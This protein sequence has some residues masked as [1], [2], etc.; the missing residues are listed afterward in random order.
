VG[1]LLTVRAAIGSVFKF[2]HV[3]GILGSHGCECEDRCVLS[4]S[5]V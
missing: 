3:V 1:F 5:A 4:C 2:A